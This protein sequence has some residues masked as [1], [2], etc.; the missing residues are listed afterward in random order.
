[1]AAITAYRTYGQFFSDPAANPIGTNEAEIRSSYRVIYSD[2][3]VDDSPPTVGDLEREILA[4]FSEPIGAVVVMVASEGST[5]GVLNL[6]HGHALY[7]SRPS[8]DHADRGTSFCYKGKV[9][10]TYAYTFTFDRNQLRMT[11]YVNV[12]RTA[13]FQHK[14]LKGEPTKDRVGPFTQDA[15]NFHTIRTRTSMFTPFVLVELLLGKD[16]TAREVYLTVYTLLEAKDLLDIFRP[17]IEFLQ[18]A[19]TQ[20]NDGNPRPFTIQ[21]R[22]GKADYPVRPQ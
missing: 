6:T 15:A 10:G 16:Y 12:P 19:S 2:Y 20:P 21:D 1:M 13:N 14:L 5:T 8:R 4:D 11:L 3:R 18:V 22:L 7:S 9:D 17:M